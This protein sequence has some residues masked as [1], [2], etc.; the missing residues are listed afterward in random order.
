MW[1]PSIIGAYPQPGRV[2]RLDVHEGARHDI[3]KLSYSFC[4]EMNKFQT[5]VVVSDPA[6]TRMTDNIK[7]KR[8]VLQLCNFQNA[9]L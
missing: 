5:I 6:D 2:E 1:L 8:I 7:M 3:A 4:P 9:N